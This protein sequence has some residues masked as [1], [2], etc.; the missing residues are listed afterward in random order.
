MTSSSTA[1]PDTTP[2]KLTYTVPA[3]HLAPSKGAVFAVPGAGTWHAAA[4]GAADVPLYERVSFET[5]GTGHFTP[6]G[7]AH[8]TVGAM[9]R[10]ETVDE[11]QVVVMCCGRESAGEAV[12]ALR[13]A[14]PY[15]VA[16]VDVVRCEL[17]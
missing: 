3:S 14:H 12:R 5:Q 9:D 1:A 11:V 8:P 15:E 17:F 13:K 16:A 7:A 6:I 4:A 10:E 2:Y